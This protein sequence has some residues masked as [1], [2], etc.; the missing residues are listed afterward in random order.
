MPDNLCH[1]FQCIAYLYPT[2]AHST[3]PLLCIDKTGQH[4]P[5]PLYFVQQDFAF[6]L[7]VTA[8]CTLVGKCVG[9]CTIYK[10][11]GQCVCPS[12]SLYSIVQLPVVQF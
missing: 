10:G 6:A 8:H 12:A 9:I 7:I 2:R 3:P 11:W 4:P 1:P 5:F